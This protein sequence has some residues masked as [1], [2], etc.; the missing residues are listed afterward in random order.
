MIMFLL[1]NRLQVIKISFKGEKRGK[2][3]LKKRGK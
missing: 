1:N 3:F 2:E